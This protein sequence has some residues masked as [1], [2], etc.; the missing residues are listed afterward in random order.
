MIELA[1]KMARGFNY[2]RVDFYNI[3]GKIYFGELAFYP[4]SGFGV[5]G[6]EWAD[7]WL[8]SLITI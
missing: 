1:E 7:E 4:S 3:D 2:V 6:P 8:G 5:Y